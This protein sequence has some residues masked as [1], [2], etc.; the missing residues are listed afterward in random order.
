MAM[1]E[2]WVK[3]YHHVG[4]EKETDGATA[5]KLRNRCAGQ[6]V[7]VIVPV[8]VGEAEMAAIWDVVS[9]TGGEALQ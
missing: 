3:R 1:D 7:P 8:M 2:P 9:A 4:P 5:R 6:C